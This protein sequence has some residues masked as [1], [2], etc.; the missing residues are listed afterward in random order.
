MLTPLKITLKDGRIFTGKMEDMYRSKY[1][2]FEGAVDEK[3]AKSIQEETG[4]QSAG[5]GFYSFRT[6]K[7]KEGCT[8][9]SW[10]CSASCD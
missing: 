5:Y 2:S 8:H 7:T 4:Y 6:W 9:T 10:A 1:F 3:T